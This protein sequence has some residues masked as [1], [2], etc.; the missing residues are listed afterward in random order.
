MTTLHYIT[1]AAYQ[2]AREQSSRSLHCMGL[3]RRTAVNLAQNRPLRWITLSQ[4]KK[5]PSLQHPS[6][7]LAI[8]LI[9]GEQ[10]AYEVTDVLRQIH[11]QGYLTVIA[12]PLPNPMMVVSEL[13]LNMRRGVV[14]LLTD[15]TS[16][17]VKARTDQ[18]ENVLHFPG[19]SRL[20]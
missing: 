2:E 4:V 18:P 15:T 10:D 19:N 5:T 12:P 8:P 3:D 9:S 6:A 14:R 16:C 11:F 13:R 1:P 7:Q 20:I 17:T